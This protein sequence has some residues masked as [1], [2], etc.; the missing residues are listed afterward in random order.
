MSPSQIRYFLSISRVKMWFRF[1]NRMNLNFFNLNTL[2]LCIGYNK[3][4]AT[5]N[6]HFC[7][8]FFVLQEKFFNTLKRNKRFSAK[9]KRKWIE[10]SCIQLKWFVNLVL[11]NISK[12]P[13]VLNNLVHY[14]LSVNSLGKYATCN[15]LKYCAI[16]NT[17]SDVIFCPE[18]MH[19]AIE[20]NS[21]DPVKIF[22]I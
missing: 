3:R 18:K 11:T 2:T 20:M 17:I 5:F 16:E 12:F 4:A 22:K 8:I 21:V 14:P 15:I 13:N 19:V 6:P 1:E 10:N 7:F 9:R